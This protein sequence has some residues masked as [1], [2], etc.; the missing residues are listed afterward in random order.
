[1]KKDQMQQVIDDQALQIS[2]QA[3]QIAD[4]KEEIKKLEFS[5]QIERRN[6]IND[7]EDKYY[8][9]WKEMNAKFMQR[10]IEELIMYDK[11]TFKFDS[12]YDGYFTMEVRMGDKYLNGF[13][14][15]ISMSRNG[16][17]E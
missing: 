8:E 2:R 9:H 13:S 3:K 10:Y 4:C 1:M 17:E 7:I 15:R 5:N 11:L 12:D 16:L 6:V 14:G